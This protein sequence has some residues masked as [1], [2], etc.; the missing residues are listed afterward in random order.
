M[1]C[2]TRNP[3]DA[4]IIGDAIQVRVLGLNGNQVRIGI[5][6]PK[7]VA[8]HREEIYDEIQPGEASRALG[9]S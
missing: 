9:E 8:V 7:Q 2:L 3:G 4:I 6:A 1:L 5:V